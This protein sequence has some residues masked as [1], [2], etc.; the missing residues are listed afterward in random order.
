MEDIDSSPVSPNPRKHPA[1]EEDSPQ[2][3][4]LNLKGTQFVMPTPPDTDQSSNASPAYENG[5]NARQGSPTPSSS[6]LSSVEIVSSNPVPGAETTSGVMSN[7][8]AASRSG[9]PPAKKRK[10]LTPAEKEQQIREKEAKDAE[11]AEQKAK[12]EE[13][14]RVKDEEKRVK[15][16]E[17]R[18]KAEEREAKK[19]EKELE[20]ERKAQDKM[21][22]ERSQMRLG[23]FFQKPT[24]PAKSA[25]EGESPCNTARRRSL[26]LEA[27]EAVADQITESQSPCKTAP[28]PAAETKTPIK[29]TISDYRKYFLPFE[30]QTHSSMPP[31]RG[32][33]DTEAAQEVFDH[34]VNDSSLREKY[35]LGLVDSYASLE[36]QF[37]EQ[38]QRSRGYHTV[39]MR[40]LVDQ[41]Q[42]S[43]KQPID[44]TN[45]ENDDNPMDVLQFVSRR[46]LEFSEDVRPPYSGTYTK[47]SSPRTTRKLR[48]NPFCKKR[49]DT[50]YDYDSEAEWEE[51]EE[52]EDILEDE[53]DEAESLGDANE[54][55]EF[56][57]DEEDALKNRRKMITGDLI[58]TSTGLC[59]ENELGKM[60]PTIEDS[61]SLQTMRG[62]RMGVL[63]PGFSGTTID[64]FLTVYWQNDI[65]PDPTPAEEASSTTNTLLMPP[66]RAPL[67]PRPNASANSDHTLLGAAEGMKGPIM[68]VAQKETSKAKSK[69]APRPLSKEDLDEFKDAIVGSQLSKAELMK[70]LKAR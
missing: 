61:R 67:Q 38:R 46:H 9:P 1:P 60:I 52:G 59:W 15:D 53:E 16:E 23:V 28:T 57:D 42:G 39:S 47:I 10:K 21:K 22:R 68:S 5:D 25:A 56:L 3:N 24:T 36:L 65:R 30:L 12:R 41:I 26:S 55:D 13:E 37:A 43:I 4:P 2:K 64:P 54:M 66:P 49:T 19:R 50:D 70:G 31:P 58:P 14:K 69:A 20:E 17:K 45:D 11:K 35:D 34:E 29:T 32:P 44:L 27:F 62:M 18:R 7:T 51:P 48:R 6:A 33:E 63:I 8:A 40:H